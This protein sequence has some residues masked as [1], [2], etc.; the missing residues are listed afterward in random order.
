M[1]LDLS[2]L[3]PFQLEA[4]K[5][6]DGPSLI[7]AGP[8][9]GKTLTL[10]FR[11]AY[12]ISALE[13][14]PK[15]ILAVT[16]TTKAAQEMKEKLI[17]I[18]PYGSHPF[19]YLA[20]LTV[21]TLHALG[22]SL[23]REHEEKIGLL[24]DFQIISESEQVE[25]VKELLS[26]LMP[27]EPL[28]R[29]LKWVR[30]ISEQKNGDTPQGLT[31]PDGSLQALYS[32]YEKKLRE[33]NMI[34]FDDLILKPLLLLQGFSEV[35]EVY[36]SRFKY[37]L[38]DEYQDL[39]NLQYLFLKEL[40]GPKTSVWVIGDADQAI[41]AFRGANIEHFIK[42]K[43]ENPGTTIIR[44]EQNYRST[45]TILNSALE[46]ISNNTN[47]LPPSNI[48]PL[49]PE[50]L[51]IYLFQASDHRVEAR[52]VVKEIENLIGGTRMEYHCDEPGMFGFSDI[53]ILYRLHHLSL[54]F[55]EGL[56]ESGIP[57]QVV[58]GR[59]NNVDS[60][61]G[62][63]IPFLK[64]VLNPHDNLSFRTILPMIGKRFDTKEMFLSLVEQFQKESLSVSLE[65]LIKNILREL[66]L[67]ERIK[68]KGFSEWLTL[69]EPFR[70]GP[71]STQIPQFLVTLSLLKEGETYTPKAEAVT[72][73]T[74]HA[75][76][77]LEFPVVFMV[78]LE[79]GVF[80]C[81]KFGE[82][83][84]DREE[85]R[86]LFYVGMTRAKKRLYLA[87]AKERFLFGE[88]CK[89]LPSPFILEIPP[90]K[91]E[92]IY[93]RRTP[94]KINKKIKVKQRTLFS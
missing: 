83:S 81:T 4:V 76:K 39:N 5:A 71:A 88:N 7:I 35:K 2:L 34:D 32:R 72:L 51:P 79:E 53:A 49:N 3:N 24:P 50:G 12:L 78:G 73:M 70:E 26:Q 11:I 75:A 82:R 14:D 74:V 28:N 17:K 80:P 93:D 60:I 25:L 55:G 6:P 58:G 47:R 13:T 43:K 54:P 64:M 56:Q 18:L 63:L 57:Y 23:L 52:F 59:S 33:L 36:Q 10:A 62:Y 20:L 89:A 94:S 66:E 30:R 41:Y 90:D 29:V 85:E 31:L 77:G 48:F 84:S 44:L 86:R 87:L 91:I 45:G 68:D 37:I 67:K 46:V 92:D 65:Q 16:F 1:S 21:S 19:P 40:C 15:K 9:T 42:F 61:S 22:L 27:Q 38:V 69:A 8:G